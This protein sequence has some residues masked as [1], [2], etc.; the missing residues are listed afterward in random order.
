MSWS[1]RQPLLDFDPYSSG[2]SVEGVKERY[3]LSPL[4]KLAGNENLLGA[5]YPSQR[6]PAGC[7]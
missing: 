5:S 1:R 4:I 3:G 6:F 7:V 2:L